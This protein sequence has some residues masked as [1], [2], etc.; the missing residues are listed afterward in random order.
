MGHFLRLNVSTVP[1]EPGLP[2]DSQHTGERLGQLVQQCYGVQPN[3]QPYILYLFGEASND[4][5]LMA[6][7][8][9]LSRLEGLP[10][11][12]ILNI[13]LINTNVTD[14]GVQA[15]SR[16]L[17]LLSSN[18]FSVSIRMFIPGPGTEEGVQPLF[19][20]LGSL[21]NLTEVKIDLRCH[22]VSDRGV[23]ALARALRLLQKL[24]KADI[25]LG[26]S[27]TDVG[28]QV[29]FEA[30]GSLPNLMKVGIFLGGN[31][32]SDARVQMLTGAL[33]SL[34]DHLTEVDIDLFSSSV[35]D[36]GVQ[37]LV[38]ALRSLLKLTRCK[39]ILRRQTTGAVVQ[40]LSEALGS[41]PNLT[42]SI[43]YYQ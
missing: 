15:L 37:L 11:P 27:V 35:T 19:E 32:G 23:Q 7:S 26:C 43:T 1:G 22:R 12:T 16:A 3:D 42:D 9:K 40:S 41:L 2:L 21:L 39:I 6:L 34:Q 29:L 25:N 4:E 31:M 14:K 36:A 24:T 10:N 30:L 28:M 13:H 8:Q 18:L 5:G 20:A 33:R 17:R 38:E